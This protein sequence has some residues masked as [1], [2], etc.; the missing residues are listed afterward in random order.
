MNGAHNFEKHVLNGVAFYKVNRPQFILVT[1]NAM[2]GENKDL[3]CF[4][5]TDL[6]YSIQNAVY[7]NAIG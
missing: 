3:H 7:N 6:E 1:F 2:L 5:G 4:L